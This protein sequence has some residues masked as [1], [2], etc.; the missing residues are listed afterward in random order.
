MDKTQAITELKQ[1][2]FAASLENGV[3]MVEIESEAE[4]I[5]ANRAVKE[6]NLCG[7]WGTRG[8]TN[9]GEYMQ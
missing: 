8:K 1:Q 3:V 4:R 5:R 7:S 6:L 9:E 2:G